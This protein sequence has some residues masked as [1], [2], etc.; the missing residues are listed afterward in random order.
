MHEKDSD[1]SESWYDANGSESWYDANGNV[2]HKKCPT[3]V[4]HWYDYDADG[5]LIHEQNF[6]YEY[7]YEYD[8]HGNM[9]HYKNSEGEKEWT[10]YIYVK[11]NGKDLVEWELSA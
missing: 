9:I 10:K 5:H 4:E 8:S 3:G 6:D 2:I 7:W 1:G 11:V